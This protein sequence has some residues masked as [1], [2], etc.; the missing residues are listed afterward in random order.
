MWSDNQPKNGR[1]NPL[2]MRSNVSAAGTAAM[3]IPKMTTDVVPSI[4]K[5]LAKLV[6]CVM[7]ISP[8]V[9]SIDTIPNS[10]QN[11]GDFSIYI[12]A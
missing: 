12:G 3:V 10:S 1:V 5:A 8:P 9:D 6:N 7:T 2:V 11:T 4:P